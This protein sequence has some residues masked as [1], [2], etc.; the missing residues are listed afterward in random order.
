VPSSAFIGVF[1]PC[2]GKVA[3]AAVAAGDDETMTPVLILWGHALAAILFGTLALARWRRRWDGTAGPAV[4]VVGAAAL[5][6]L[7]ALAVAGVEPR[8]ISVHVAEGARNLAWTGVM[9]A[10]VLRARA[11]G[12]ALAALYGVV[13]F[14]MLTATILAPIGQMP[15]APAMVEAVEIT[16]HVLRMMAMA[17]ALLLLCHLAQTASGRQAGGVRLFAL[18]LGAMWGLDLAIALLAFAGPRWTAMPVVARGPV[19][20]GVAVLLAIAATHRGEGS[21]AVSRTV[22]TRA[23]VALALLLYVAATALAVDF[24]SSLAPAVAR[25]VQ[26]AIVCGAAATLLAVTATPWLRAWLRVKAAKHLFDHRYDYRVE[27]Q[28]F[29]TTLGLPGEDAAPLAER[30][31]KAVAD[32]TDAPAALLLVEAEGV[33]APCAGWRWPDGGRELPAPLAAHLAATGRIVSLDS[34]RGGGGEEAA[35]VPDWVMGDAA[36][37]AIVPLLHGEAL[38]GAILLARPPVQRALDW[39]D[40]DLLRV[41]GR[42]AASHL[43][44]DRSRAALADAQQFD[45]FNRRFAFLLHD[46]KNVASQLTLVARNAERHADNP[47]FR[48]DMVVT[49]RESAGRM[50]T[51]L[52]RL[53]QHDGARPEALQPVD[54]AAL[55]TRVAA[56]RRAQHPFLVEGEAGVPAW[57]Q[58]ARLEQALAHLVQN[59]VEASAA[60]VPVRLVVGTE[61][62]GDRLVLA[63]IDRGGGMAPGFVRDR[64]F[65]PFVSSKPDGFGIGACEARQLIRAMGGEL[66]VDSRE[67]EGSTFR[68]LL[69]AEPVMAVAA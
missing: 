36:A 3:R 23:L 67:G 1:A 16:R 19:M 10:F 63:V 9:A 49:L 32:L 4:A 37:W 17:G 34:L 43:A 25:A 40:F 62:G 33:L 56:T 53:G 12:G 38:A 51:L 61:P 47:A 48:A 6:A 13:M 68:I 21:V 44:E 57:G 7:W 58:P 22:A 28:R 39:E 8:E 14:V 20:M 42:Q 24:A 30:I 15:M 50:A 69:P 27:W 45:A 41:A 35:L 26:T 65:R 18:A 31:A 29:T 66:Q 59:A 55:A 46:I 64:L 11:D 60:G 2:I 52:A 54:L 5:T